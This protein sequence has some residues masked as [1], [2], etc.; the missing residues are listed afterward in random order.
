MYTI[1]VILILPFSVPYENANSTFVAVALFPYSI[2]FPNKNI[3][4]YASKLAATAFPRLINFNQI[5]GYNG[6]EVQGSL[7]LSIQSHG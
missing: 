6:R 3:T 5:M 4:K 1:H 7:Q 2:C